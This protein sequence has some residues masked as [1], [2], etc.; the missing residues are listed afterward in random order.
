MPFF[1]AG[2]VHLDQGAVERQGR[3]VEVA[4]IFLGRVHVEQGQGVVFG[5][6]HQVEG[7]GPRLF[8][9]DDRQDLGREEGPVVDRDDVDLVRQV[10]AG[11]GQAFAGFM[12]WSAL[13]IGVFARVFGEFLLVAHGGTCTMG[14]GLRWGRLAVV[15]TVIFCNAVFRRRVQRRD[16]LAGFRLAAGLSGLQ[17]AFLGAG[18]CR[19]WLASD[20]GLTCNNNVRFQTVIAGKPA[21]TVG[22]RATTKKATPVRASPLF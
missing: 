9:D 19:S 17:R 12:L 22:I 15:S 5:L 7:L 10:L 2:V 20:N 3:G 18:L 4:R 8:V 1:A 13:R 6:G 21:P 16:R 14:M 11:Q